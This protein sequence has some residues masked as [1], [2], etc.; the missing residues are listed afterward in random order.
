MNIRIRHYALIISC[1]M[2]SRFAGPAQT[3]NLT[4]PI[5][6]QRAELDPQYVSLHASGKGMDAT[7][8]SVLFRESSRAEVEQLSQ[9]SVFVPCKVWIMDDKR[10][11]VKATLAGMAIREDNEG[12]PK[13]GLLLS[14]P[15]LS[16][17]YTA[18][19]ILSRSRPSE[20]AQNEWLQWQETGQTRLSP[21]EAPDAASETNLY[22]R[23][24]RFDFK[25][26]ESMMPEYHSSLDGNWMKAGSYSTTFT[27][28]FKENDIS[29]GGR[30]EAFFVKTTR[31]W[32]IVRT[33]RAKHE[34]IEV[35]FA[36]LF[37]PNA[38]HVENDRLRR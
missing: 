28:L 10:V 31:P 36:N 1:I 13:Y 19:A 4:T 33:T 29:L 38:P 12:L 26:I 25:K 27:R 6:V 37:P 17:A 5:L 2:A 24:Y 35:L 15:A 3:L 14:F 9:S 8:V 20:R 34:K 22:T 16:D 32:M 7:L 30:G 11:V 18:T 21:A 23:T